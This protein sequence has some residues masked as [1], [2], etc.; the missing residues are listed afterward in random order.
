M[1]VIFDRTLGTRGINNADALQNSHLRCGNAHRARPLG[2]GFNE[3]I[4]KRLQRRI[5]R[6][7][8]LAGGF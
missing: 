4:D 7:N 3:V 1:A 8:G 6:V 2:A 5:K